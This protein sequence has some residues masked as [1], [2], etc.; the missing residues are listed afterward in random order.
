M[1][2]VKVNLERMSTKLVVE[3]IVGI[4]INVVNLTMIVK[5]VLLMD[6]NFVQEM[7]SVTIPICI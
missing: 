1:A 2:S 4:V 6:V 3:G 5:V 7:R